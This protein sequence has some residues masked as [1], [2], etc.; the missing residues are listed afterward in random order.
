MNMSTDKPTDNAWLRSGGMVLVESS[1][2]GGKLCDFHLAREAINWQAKRIKTLE[3]QLEQDTPNAPPLVDAAK[4]TAY[5][6]IESIYDEHYQDENLDKAVNNAIAEGWQPF[7]GVSIVNTRSGGYVCTQAM[8][9][10]E[11]PAT[12]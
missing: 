11:Q 10:Y 3:M 9:Q 12:A 4:I 5:K 7:G 2:T 8:V 6:T 1:P